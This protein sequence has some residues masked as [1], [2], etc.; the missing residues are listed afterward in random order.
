[1]NSNYDMLL[2]NTLVD[3]Y[4]RSNSFRTGANS[5]RRILIKLYDNGE[6]NFP[7]YDTENHNIRISINQAVQK[8]SKLNFLSYSWMKGEENHLLAKVWLNLE[9]LS[10]I[11]L[12]LGRAQKG[13]TIDEVCI[14]LLCAIDEVDARWAKNFLQD[15]YDA[16]SKSRTIGSRLPTSAEER[17]DLLHCIIFASKMKDAEL[18]ERV[19]S[20]QCFGDSKHFEK[21]VRSRLLSI[22][23]HYLEADIDA[24]D[25]DLLRQIGITKYPEQFEFCGTISHLGDLVETCFGALRYGAAIFSGELERGRFLIG[26]GVQNIISIENRANFIDYI[27][28]HKRDNDLVIYH[29]GQYSPVK[30]RFFKMLAAAMPTGCNWLHWGDID[31]GGFS[32]LL[33]LRR[34]IHPD[35][36]AHHMG[37]AELTQHRN[38]CASFDS[39]YEKRLQTLLLRSELSDCHDCIEFMLDN[40]IRL[41]QE[42]LLVS[43][44]PHVREDTR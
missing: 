42:A 40:K 24:R 14:Q 6:N 26:D 29:G 19:F 23:R 20:L 34:E 44:G 5:S 15:M 30:K 4:E 17:A 28:K 39:G 37:K 12:Y 41:E 3:K 18:L 8:L 2:L 33:R 11:H 35:V 22:L 27:Q 25:E 1:M 16:I 32:M 36:R 9:S 13:D 43:H 38:L 10:E 21:T 31:Y 7:A